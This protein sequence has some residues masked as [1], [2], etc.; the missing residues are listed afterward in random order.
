MR[1]KVIKY[2]A[3]SIIIAGGLLFS[4]ILDKND[5]LNIIMSNIE[6]LGEVPE[7]HTLDCESALLK[8]CE[9]TCNRCQISLSANGKPPVTVTCPLD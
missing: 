6:A 5:N 9:A 7:G 4:P 1:K 8:T 3:V 2:I